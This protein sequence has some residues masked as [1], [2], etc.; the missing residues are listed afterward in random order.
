MYA[1]IIIYVY[2][3]LCYYYYYYTP[4]YIERDTYLL[5]TYI[6]I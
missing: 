2:Y 6:C 5:Y 4:I 3:D 1:Y